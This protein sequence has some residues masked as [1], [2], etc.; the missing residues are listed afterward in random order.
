MTDFLQ[1]VKLSHGLFISI[2]LIG[3][4]GFI[5][6]ER[7]V[8]LCEEC[9]PVLLLLRQGIHGFDPDEEPSLEVQ[10]GVQ[11]EEDGVNG[12]TGH[13]SL[14][15]H[16]LLESLECFEILDIF[17]FGVDQLRHHI[18]SPRHILVGLGRDDITHLRL[19]EEVP[20][21]KCVKHS[22]HHRGDLSHVHVS[23][24]MTPRLTCE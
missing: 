13:F 9:A 12:I 1:L 21:L 16:Q 24:P 11:V 17:P 4:I 19:E 6:S 10:Q 15:L 7:I 22:V 5:D 23:I 20:V 2:L 8:I 18:V 3:D 14:L